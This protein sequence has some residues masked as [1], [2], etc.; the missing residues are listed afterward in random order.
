MFAGW[1]FIVGVFVRV[2]L[3]LI[4]IKKP[5]ICR[6][7]FGYELVMLIFNESL[8]NMNSLEANNTIQMLK[9]ILYFISFNYNT[10]RSFV[11]V[12][13]CQVALKTIR[14]LTYTEFDGSDALV[15]FCKD[16]LLLY[17][18]LLSCHCLMKYAGEMYVSKD[19]L[20]QGTTQLLREQETGLIILDSSNRK[21]LFRNQVFEKMLR[22]DN[23]AA[24]SDREMS[25]RLKG[26]VLDFELYACC[27][28]LLIR[29]AGAAAD[30][31][32]TV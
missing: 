1:A 18:S 15:Y 32:Q 24:S 25:E 21:V 29:E 12:T 5:V 28:N 9:I 17:I 23:H 3:L 20:S 10:G 30:H 13:I 2:I 11:I 26:D 16:L 27:D 7:Y 14:F 6:I 8:V 31:D 22:I 19:I 4:S